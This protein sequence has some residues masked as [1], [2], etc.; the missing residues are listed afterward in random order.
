[1]KSRVAG[2]FSTSSSGKVSDR[3]SAYGSGRIC[4][5][6]GCGTRLSTYN[7]GLWC[8]LHDTLAPILP[9]RR[10][11]EARVI[12]DPVTATPMRT[13]WRVPPLPYGGTGT[14]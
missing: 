8:S 2:R 1:M 7:P 14:K 4:L 5:A 12:A 9:R 6:P 13:G 11:P 3:I 10:P